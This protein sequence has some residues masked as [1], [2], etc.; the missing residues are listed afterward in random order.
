MGGRIPLV[1]R[2]DSRL[3]LAFR[4][5]DQG[6]LLPCCLWLTLGFQ[7]TL[8]GSRSH[9]W[10]VYLNNGYTPARDGKF[11]H[12]EAVEIREPCFAVGYGALLEPY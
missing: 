3:T 12:G 1:A 4:R 6:W 7:N 9:C 10:M 11:R 2:C 8:R 5:S